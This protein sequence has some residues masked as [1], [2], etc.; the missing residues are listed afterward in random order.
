MNI[1]IPALSS[2]ILGLVASVLV[3]CWA[4][5]SHSP[6]IL[7]R[8]VRVIDGN[9]G[10]PLEHADIL[11]TGS[12]IT[13]IGAAPGNP[14]DAQAG[15]HGADQRNPQSASHSADQRNAP[16]AGHSAGQADAQPATQ[17]VTGN[18]IQPPPNTTIIKLTG[19]TVL[20]GLISDHSHLGLVKGTTASGSNITRANILRQLKQYTAYGVTTVTSLGLNLAPFYAVQPQAHSGATRT[21]D[22][23]GADK[24]FGAPNSAPPASLDTDDV[25]RPSTPEEARSQVRETAQRHPDLLKI[26]VDDMHGRF[27]TKMNPEV[28]KAVIDE[29]HANGLRV[30]AHVY[31]LDDAR[32]LIGNGVDIL[33]HGVRD[34]AVDSDFT[35]AIKGRGAWYVPTLGLDESYYI[36]A[37]HPEWLQQPFFR[38]SLPPALAAQLNDTAWRAKVLADT[39]TLAAEKQALATNMKN[40]KT[41]FDAGVNIGFGTDSGATP[42]RIAGFA[43]H[44]ELKLL[45]DAGLTPLQ[46]IQTATKNSA[47]LLHLDDRGVIAP[48][49]LADLLVVDGDPSK[50]ISAVDNIE[51]VWRRGKKVADA[52][53]FKPRRPKKPA[54]E[55]SPTPP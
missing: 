52:R 23:F 38:R 17:P 46:A 22:L 20:P 18:A 31:Y 11:I 16:S 51:S 49:K 7:L 4:K 44:R 21:A 48:G 1:R 6:P 53:W 40:V 19:K 10:P 54:P 9:G 50:D 45:T 15:N 8:D 34:K 27:A 12:K 29:A 41:L 39:K 26:W 33:A 47:A 55:A 32:Q 14:P 5:G 42:L 36:Y 28:Y 35:Q 3:P 43:E 37:E 2:A 24:G 13:A 25:Y 30:A